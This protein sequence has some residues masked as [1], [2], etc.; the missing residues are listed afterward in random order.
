MT[1]IQ[2]LQGQE[3]E[4]FSQNIKQIAEFNKKHF[5]SDKFFNQVTS[6]L[7]R[8]LIR[9][10]QQVNRTRG[11]QHLKML[12]LA[13]KIHTMGEFKMRKE[14]TQLLRQLR[15]SYLYGQTSPGEDPVV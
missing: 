8:N 13:K 6:E 2:K 15:Q 3:L 1:Q 5:F 10:R 12:S 11:K 14:K 9:A 4:T 7:K